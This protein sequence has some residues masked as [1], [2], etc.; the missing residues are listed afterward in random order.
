MSKGIGEVNSVCWYQYFLSFS[1]CFFKDLSTSAQAT[2]ADDNN[3]SRAKG[4]DGEG[5][6]ISKNIIV[7]I[8]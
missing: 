1:Y 6:I 8:K 4:L 3:I 7:E 5:I 2:G